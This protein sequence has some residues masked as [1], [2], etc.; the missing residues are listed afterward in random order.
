[1]GR[2]GDVRAASA[3]KAALKDQDR[4]VR[5][6]AALALGRLGTP[7]AAPALVEILTFGDQWARFDAARL[8]SSLG[9]TEVVP[10]LIGAMKSGD[11]FVRRNA[12]F[13]LGLLGDT[14]A[15]A[16]LEA[17]LADDSEQVRAN[18]ASSLGGLGYH[19]IVPVLITALDRDDVDTRADAAEVLGLLGNQEA[20]TPLVSKLSDSEPQVRV[21]AIESLGRLGAREAVPDLVNLLDDQATRRAA[22]LALANLGDATVFPILFS[23]IN[24]ENRR[25][26]RAAESAI[27]T[28]VGHNDSVIE[29]LSLVAAESEGNQGLAKV[30]ERLRFNVEKTLGH[31]PQA[32]LD[33]DS[34]TVGLVARQSNMVGG[35]VANVG[36]GPA[37]D[38]TISLGLQGFEA[39]HVVLAAFPRIG[40]GESLNW[41]G[42]YVPGLAGTVPLI[43]SLKYRDFNGL[44][45]RIIREV[46]TVKDPSITPSVVV[47]GDLLEQ[48][49]IKQG[50]MGIA[51]VRGNA[52][53]APDSP[54]PTPLRPK[55][56]PHCGGSLD[57][58]SP[59][60]FC[61]H[62][63]A[64]LDI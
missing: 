64:A 47:H 5:A 59:P 18:S 6:N 29:Q 58:A 41:S 57:L 54:S 20:V 9:D 19:Q 3:L 28:L 45:D 63:G 33:M 50:E 13:S 48:G 34:G 39:D 51:M 26:R 36:Q 44:C 60:R 10:T 32:V 23:L 35:M 53:L 12:A 43:W 62:C 8:L 38:V 14:R 31:V 49:S 2:I 22:A 37:F 15:M 27:A 17:A 46:V 11:E 7:E 30:L 16:C 42:P 52:A 56:C 24:H 55:F 21:K 61:P 1:M 4:V 40:K 25:V